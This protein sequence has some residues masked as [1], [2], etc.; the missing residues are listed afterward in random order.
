MAAVDDIIKFVELTDYK[1][2]DYEIAEPKYKHDWM[3]DGFD[4]SCTYLVTDTNTGTPCVVVRGGRNSFQVYS[5]VHPTPENDYLLTCSWYDTTLGV[6]KSPGDMSVNKKN[7]P[8]MYATL[9]AMND[10]QMGQAWDKA[11]VLRDQPT[12]DQRPE[13]QDS[14][15]ISL[16]EI[17]FTALEF[18]RCATHLKEVRDALAVLAVASSGKEWLFLKS[19]EKEVREYLE[20]LVGTLT[21][22]I[23]RID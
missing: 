19:V 7:R 8:E 15:T 16:N 11:D 1:F 3:L 21:E 2:I 23:S 6:V 17:R 18:A 10:A 20:E 12:G 9:M 5:I 14:S 4:R 22:Q 13:S